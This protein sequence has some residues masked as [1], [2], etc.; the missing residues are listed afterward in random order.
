MERDVRV[1]QDSTTGEWPEWPVWA[2]YECAS[3]YSGLG[4]TTLWRLC[5]E[6]EIIYARVGS[7][8]LINLPSLDEYLHRQ[9]QL[10]NREWT[11]G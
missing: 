9:A 1:E 8:V 4:R 10:E 2:S 6:G 5:G 7:R 3:A 11:N